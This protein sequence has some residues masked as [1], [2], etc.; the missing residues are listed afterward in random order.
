MSKFIK[1]NT[2]CQLRVKHCGV[3]DEAGEEVVRLKNLLF[4]EVVK[5]IAFF[6]AGIHVAATGEDI[7]FGAKFPRSVIDV[8]VEVFEKFRPS[9][10]SSIEMS[11]LVEVLKVFVVG[12]D[13]DT[14][15]G[16][17]KVM[18]PVIECV[19][20][21]LVVDVVVLLGGGHGAGKKCDGVNVVVRRFDL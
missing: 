16:T 20:E 15:T 8:K 2:F 11:F 10:L 12:K 6:P 9:C 17:F 21:F 19:D 18:A 3:E 14:V 5:R 4:V 7:G 1:T 13:F